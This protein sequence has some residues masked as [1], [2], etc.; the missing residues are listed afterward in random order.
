LHED[1]ISPDE[2]GERRVNKLITHVTVPG[3]APTAE[4]S[5][6]SVPDRERMRAIALTGIPVA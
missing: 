4:M 5:G 2:S 6:A 3:L 1:L